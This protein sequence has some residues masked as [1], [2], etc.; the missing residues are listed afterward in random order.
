MIVASSSTCMSQPAPWSKTLLGDRRALARTRNVPFSI[1]IDRQPFKGELPPLIDCE[2]VRNIISA[3]DQ[4]KLDDLLKL[5]LMLYA[6]A[7]NAFKHLSGGQFSLRL[8]EVAFAND[9]GM[10]CS[11]D[12]QGFTLHVQHI[13]NFAYGM[14]SYDKGHFYLAPIAFFTSKT[15]VLSVGTMVHEI[16]HGF[17]GGHSNDKGGICDVFRPEIGLSQREAEYLSWPHVPPVSI[18]VANPFTTAPSPL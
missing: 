9:K 1:I 6:K 5:N 10:D 16:M 15:S 4:Y 2:N 3:W 7:N 18:H 13:Y 17:L 8:A 11:I 12:N 14:Y